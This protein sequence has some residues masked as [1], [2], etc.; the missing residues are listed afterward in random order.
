[1]MCLRIS[2]SILAT[3]FVEFLVEDDKIVTSYHPLVA[4]TDIIQIL[5]KLRAGI[6]GANAPFLEQHIITT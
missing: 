5:L 1:M 6:G 4:F 2:R 3:L